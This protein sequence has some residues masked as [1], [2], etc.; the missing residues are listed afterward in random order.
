MKRETL[1]WMILLLAAGAYIVVRAL[2]SGM[3]LGYEERIGGDV[4]PATA[5][6][7]LAGNGRLSIMRSIGVWVAALGT[8]FILSFVYKDNPLYK[9]A[10]ST[11]VGVSAAY[12]MVVG[13]WSTIIP[14]LLGKLFPA[15]VQSWAMPGLSPERLEWWW[16]YSFPLVLGVML[17]WRLSPKGS[18]FSRWP[19]AF[20]IGVFCG[21][22]LIGFI[23]ADFLS[24]IRN[25]IVPLAV[26]ENGS[27]DFWASLRNL[28]LVGGV[29]CSLVYFFFSFEH[30][31][32]V[33]KTAKVGIWVLMITFGA[34][35][36]YTVMGRIAL[37]AIR[38][39][40]LFDDWLWLIDRT[41]KRPGF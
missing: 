29:L 12:W 17:L 19:L 21:I 18:W 22:R 16:L 30:K 37:L 35:F 4:F 38:L 26:L 7:A 9:I 6:D 32:F 2:T 15:W 5:W 10:E 1:I 33:G 3:G 23:H 24:Q 14:N 11:F 31:G 40:F 39:E 28:L 8:L 20:V 27:F 36:G 41:D 25:S 34:A 13:F